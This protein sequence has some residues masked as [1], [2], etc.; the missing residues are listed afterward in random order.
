LDIKI[1]KPGIKRSR[2]NPVNLNAGRKPSW[3]N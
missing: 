2:K 1:L 3:R